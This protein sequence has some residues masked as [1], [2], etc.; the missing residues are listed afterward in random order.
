MQDGETGAF[1]TFLIWD[2]IT[3]RWEW[4][5]GDDWDADGF[6]DIF[7][8]RDGINITYDIPKYQ[9]KWIEQEVKEHA[10]YQAPSPQRVSQAINA[11]FNKTF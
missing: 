5:E 7:V 4:C 9:F 10:G 2:E 3:V 8:Y 6:F 11:H 1:I